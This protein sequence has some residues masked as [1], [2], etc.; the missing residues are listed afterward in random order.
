MHRRGWRSRDSL[1]VRWLGAFEEWFGGSVET[2]TT[3]P[4]V[5]L[6]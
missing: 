6:E 2:G 3:Y 5:S 4:S 1:V